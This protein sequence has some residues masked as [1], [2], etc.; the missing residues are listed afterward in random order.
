MVE[1]SGGLFKKF[2][3]TSLTGRVQGRFY[4]FTDTGNHAPDPLY[5]TTP[6]QGS[7]NTVLLQSILG[8]DPRARD[9]QPETLSHRDGRDRKLS[10]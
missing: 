9:V 1:S 4:G 2:T 8:E 3:V 10:D 5:P 7:R 6:V